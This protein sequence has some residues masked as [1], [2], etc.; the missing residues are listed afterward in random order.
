MEEYI[1]FKTEMIPVA[2]SY[3]TVII[4]GGTAGAVCGIRAAREGNRVLIV[5]KGIALGGAPRR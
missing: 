4:G 3:D 2:G 1:E 5:E